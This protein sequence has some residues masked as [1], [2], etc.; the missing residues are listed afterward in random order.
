MNKNFVNGTRLDPDNPNSGFING[1]NYDPYFGT[2]F[3]TSDSSGYSPVKIK[4]A[5]GSYAVNLTNYT[6]TSQSVAFNGTSS[7]QFIQN[8][9]TITF[10][11][12]INAPF[13]VY[14]EYVPYN[15]R[16]RLIMRKNI[17]NLEIPARADSVL[18]KMKTT[19]FDPY[20]DKLNYVS[21][22]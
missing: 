7:V 12:A 14:Y 9:R 2:I 11:T 8:G 4:L 19:Y 22:G 10:N 1:A 18:L 17:P 20:Y 16:F 6:N 3:N 21:K 15:L 13:T 5:D